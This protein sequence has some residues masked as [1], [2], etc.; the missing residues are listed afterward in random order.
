MNTY[1]L[2]FVAF[3]DTGRHNIIRITHWGLFHVERIQFSWYFDYRWPSCI[4]SLLVHVFHQLIWFTS[5]PWWFFSNAIIICIYIIF[6]CIYIYMSMLNPGSRSFLVPK[7]TVFFSAAT[8]PVTLIRTQVRR[9]RFES[10]HWRLDMFFQ[11][12]KM[13]R[14]L[15]DRNLSYHSYVRD[16]ILINIMCSVHFKPVVSF[17]Q[18]QMIGE[19]GF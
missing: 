6:L 14:K 9:V 4:L 3:C 11:G 12:D 13:G 10:H 5:F 19:V 8:S 7:T 17:F 18:T 2:R 16:R 1:G 15:C